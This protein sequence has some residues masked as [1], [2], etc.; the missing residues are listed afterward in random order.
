[1]SVTRIVV[2]L[3]LKPTASK[4]D[5]EQWARTTDLPTV[6]GLASVEAFEVFEATG[7]LG[8]NGA[9]PYDY[10]EIL[11]VADMNLFGTETASPQMQRIAAEFQAWSDPVFISTRR[12]DW[13]KA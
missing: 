9:A 8:A 10:I 3:K 1:M 11:D 5:Y 12:L 7:L 2:L 6:N 4:A 13:V